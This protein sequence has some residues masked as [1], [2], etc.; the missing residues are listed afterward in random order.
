V[1]NHCRLFAR[2]KPKGRQQWRTI[3][4]F[5]RDRSL[6]PTHLY[7]VCNHPIG[8][9]FSPWT[10]PGDLVVG[11]TGFTCADPTTLCANSQRGATLEGLCAPPGSPKSPVNRSVVS[12]VKTEMLF[13]SLCRGAISA[14]HVTRSTLYMR[15]VM[16][17]S[18]RFRDMFRA[19]PV[20]RVP[21]CSLCRGAVGA[22][23][24]CVTAQ[25]SLCM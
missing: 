10:L 19:V 25:S 8:A 18:S 17:F 4:D 22:L 23:T 13:R 20:N 3:V 16:F 7:A 9:H 2:P 15:L 5:L 24:F 12:Q 1:A 6:K 11:D 21:L 14:L